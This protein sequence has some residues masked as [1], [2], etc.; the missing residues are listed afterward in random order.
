MGLLASAP[1]RPLQGAQSPWRLTV[2]VVDRQGQALHCRAWVEVGGE[3]LFRPSATA[4]CTPYPRDR[5]FSCDGRFTIDVPAARALIHVE[6][7]KEY[8]PVNRSIDMGAD[9]EKAITITLQRW[10]DMPAEGWY[11]GDLHVHLGADDP[12]VLRQLALADDVHVT[13]A[14]TYWLRGRESQW[15]ST[16][17]SFG[18]GEPW[19][20]DA[21][22]LITRTAVEIERIQGDAIPGGS[23][24]ASFL[25]NLTR[26]LAAERAGEHFPTDAAL[27]LAAR[28]HSPDVVIDTDKP[29]WA[30]TVVG[31]AL[32]AYDTVQ[33]CH[34]H[35]HRDQTL[36]GGWGM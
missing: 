8:R 10:I 30:E 34:N 12:Q 26:P 21:T 25:F 36:S 2:R 7:G 35:Y 11:S 17:P 5:S 24:G 1:I 4:S 20:I 16:W 33:V 31:A 27:C 9:R 18:E 22:H 13:P 32:G 6:R 28:R 29:S 15:P 19:V 23:V 3:R 14:F